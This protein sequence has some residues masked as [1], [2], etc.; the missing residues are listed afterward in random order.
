MHRNRKWILATIP[1][2]SLIAIGSSYGQAFYKWV[3]GNGVTQYTQTPPPQRHVVDN[4]SA[5]TQ[6]PQGSAPDIKRRNDHSKKNPKKSFAEEQAAESARKNTEADADSR[7]KNAA[8][9]QQLKLNLSQLK[10]GQRFR[11]MDINGDRSYLSE[12]Q[13]EAQ[14]KQQTAQIENYCP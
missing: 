8:V 3:D 13:K 1:L 10:S 6:A 12:E 7:N 11:T 2:I 5:S 14:I 9:C 4:I